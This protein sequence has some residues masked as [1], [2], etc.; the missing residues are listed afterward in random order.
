MYLF[1]WGSGA[2]PFVT[3]I[4]NTSKGEEG[5][6]E[7][8]EKRAARGSGHKG[9]TGGRKAA[10]RGEN[11]RKTNTDSMSYAFGPLAILVSI[12]DEANGR[13]TQYNSVVHKDGHTK[14][15]YIYN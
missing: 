1:V 14:Y 4:Q 15:I 9:R 13:I 6:E 8:G 7:T 3:N 12:N 5:G 10:G 11:K 2:T